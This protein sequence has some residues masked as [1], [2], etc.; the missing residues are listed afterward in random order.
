ME[1][2]EMPLLKQVKGNSIVI[3]RLR[4]Y[5]EYTEKFERSI[6][7]AIGKEYDEISASFAQNLVK[8]DRMGFDE[9]GFFTLGKDVWIIFDKDE[10]CLLGYEVITRKRGG[11]IKLGPTYIEPSQRG[12]G[13]AI[14]A[15]R[16]LINV[17]KDLGVRKVYVTA[18]LGNQGTVSLDF[19]H[20][21]FK[22]EALLHKHYS[23]KGSER[24]CGKFIV[25][26]RE[27]IPLIPR[28]HY[29]T[30]KFD[31]ILINDFGN[32]SPKKFSDFIVRNMS[33]DY[34]DIDKSFV[35]GLCNS[36]NVGLDASYER[37]GKLLINSFSN[38]SLES[39]A[40]ITLKR[41]GVMKVNPLIIT[42]DFLSLENIV[43]ILEIIEKKAI[44]YQRRKITFLISV[45]DLIVVNVLSYNQ[46]ICEGVIREP[47]KSGV[48]MLVLSRFL[49]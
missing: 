24:V 29:G 49:S 25:E 3:K 33:I 47:Y 15:I 43:C 23:D 32:Y 18:P 44:E 36:M 17:Y 42:D 39:V 28:I 9:Y 37:K 6:T 35:N 5:P 40:V 7:K 20:L 30:R 31:R 41:G 45:R 19:Q 14:Q 27:D 2:L 34:D 13:Y 1:R 38:T 8:I 12:K 4:D 21:S 16:E 11:C 26:R 10:E 48:D 46:Y 22:L